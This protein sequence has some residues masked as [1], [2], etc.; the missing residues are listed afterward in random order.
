M[1][2]NGVPVG[3]LPDMT[4]E[5]GCVSLR[6]NDVLIAYS[7]GITEATDET[8]EEFGSERLHATAR[9]AAAGAPAETIRRI[10]R[11]VDTFA[12]G[13]QAD[14]QTLLVLKRSH[15]VS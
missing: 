12:R 4:W 11:E 5:V 6:P 15:S 2:A 13:I 7:D 10:S 8:G 14:D 3:L 9:H 1:V